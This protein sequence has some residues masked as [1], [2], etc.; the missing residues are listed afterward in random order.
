MGNEKFKRAKTEMEKYNEVFAD[1]WDD[2]TTDLDSLHYMKF[3][4][5][6]VSM[7][8]PKLEEIEVLL[9]AWNEYYGGTESE[10]CG[11]H[12]CKTTQYIKS[13]EN[14][15]QKIFPVSF[16]DGWAVPHSTKETP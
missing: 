3:F 14:E 13:I 6:G 10:N 1:V 2:E 7:Y 9:K 15:G 5:A 4:K 8:K 16:R 11:C 12:I